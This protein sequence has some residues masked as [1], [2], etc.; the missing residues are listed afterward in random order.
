M[1][2]IELAA[3]VTHIWFLKGIPGYLG[4]ILDIN[5]RQLEEVIYYDSKPG[6]TSISIPSS[7]GRAQGSTTAAAHEDNSI[8][9]L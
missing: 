5:S 4:I 7:G 2:H 3:P 6:A 9:L 8:V 1:G